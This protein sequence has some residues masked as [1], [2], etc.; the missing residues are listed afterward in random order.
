ME[1]EQSKQHHDGFSM[2]AGPACSLGQQACFTAREMIVCEDGQSCGAPERRF[3]SGS[4]CVVQTAAWLEDRLQD[5]LREVTEALYTEGP[6][7]AD[8]LYLYLCRIGDLLADE[9]GFFVSYIEFLYRNSGD[10]ER[11]YRRFADAVGS[12]S[13][14]QRIFERGKADGTVLVTDSPELFAEYLAGAMFERL[15]RLILFYGAQPDTMIAYTDSYLESILQHY[16]R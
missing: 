10:R 1:L 5:R 15:G 11:D 6:T 16:C 8:L 14:L 4:D 12:Q 2:Q 9:S 13:V 7:A 3:F